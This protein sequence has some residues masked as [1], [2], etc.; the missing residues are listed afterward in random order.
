MN[1]KPFK[2]TWIFKARCDLILLN[3]AIYGNSDRNI[4]CS[5]CNLRENENINHF[6][7]RCL[8]LREFRL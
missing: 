3:N 4:E 1:F 7:G 2:I 6:M 8:I 5:L